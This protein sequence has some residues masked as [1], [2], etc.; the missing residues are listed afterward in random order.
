MRFI[1]AAIDTQT[2]PTT[3]PELL[4][5]IADRLVN[6]YGENESTDYISA[7]RERAR[8]GQELLDLAEKLGY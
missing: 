8:L 5:F 1:V 2:G 7:L 4:N 3:T 6:K